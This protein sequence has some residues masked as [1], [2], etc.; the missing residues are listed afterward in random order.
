[1]A[2]KLDI[3]NYTW[4]R[5]S[6]RLIYITQDLLSEIHAE[7]H[8]SMSRWPNSSSLMIYLIV[9][10][11]TRIMFSSIHDFPAVRLSTWFYRVSNQL[12]WKIKNIW[13]TVLVDKWWKAVN[14]MIFWNLCGIYNYRYSAVCVCVHEVCI[15]CWN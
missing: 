13:A 9:S 12:L 3:F 11:I 8:F 14:F 1:M 10:E 4:T 2:L 5:L 6:S 7:N 15:G